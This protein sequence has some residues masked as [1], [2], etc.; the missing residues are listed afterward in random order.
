MTETTKKVLELLKT[1]NRVVLTFRKRKE[2]EMAKKKT[3][4]KEL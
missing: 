2:P 4:K 3:A 1:R